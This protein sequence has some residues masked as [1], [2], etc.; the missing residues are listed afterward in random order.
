[1]RQ[2]ISRAKWL[3]AVA[4]CGAAA[5]G[6]NLFAV[7]PAAAQTAPIPS[8]CSTSTNAIYSA[9]NTTFEGGISFVCVGD[10]GSGV[11][12]LVVG[13]VIPGQSSL[14]APG[15]YA[16]YL[17]KNGVVAHKACWGPAS[18]CPP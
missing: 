6:A 9:A 5:T 10:L 13:A 16:L 3:S 8:S 15:G 2:A 14:A 4:L 11:P 12:Q 18:D 7:T 17:N 1:M